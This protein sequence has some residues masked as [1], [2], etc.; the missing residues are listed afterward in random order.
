MLWYL[1]LLARFYTYELFPCELTVVDS[2]KLFPTLKPKDKFD[3]ESLN[4]EVLSLY[5]YYALVSDDNFLSGS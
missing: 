5:F 1:G 3:K 4:D 2:L